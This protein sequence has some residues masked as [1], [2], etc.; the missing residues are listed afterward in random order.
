MRKKKRKTRKNKL[1]QHWYGQNP[2]LFS[3]IRRRYA[4]PYASLALPTS[5]I[6]DDYDDIVLR[7]L[8]PYQ[9]THNPD[10]NGLRR[11]Y[12][13]AKRAALDGDPRAVLVLRE[14]EKLLA[15]DGLERM[16]IL[17][18]KEARSLKKNPRRKRVKRGKP[19]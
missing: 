16:R 9:T 4:S 2:N 1:E 13:A 14:L 18:N 10:G 8:A 17:R 12:I 3:E 19:K 6:P 5:I 7:N 15:E 11:A